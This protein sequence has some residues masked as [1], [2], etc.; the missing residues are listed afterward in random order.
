MSIDTIPNQT[1]F[2]GLIYNP[3]FFSTGNSITLT[4]AT[5][6]FLK[7]TGTN[8]TSDAVLTSFTGNV[9]LN[10]LSTLSDASV[11]GNITV[12]GNTSIIGISNFSNITN[13]SSPTI[14]SNTAS[15]IYSGGIIINKDTYAS[16]I[17]GNNIVTTNV[18][19]ANLNSSNNITTINFNS[20]KITCNQLQANSVFYKGQIGANINIGIPPYLNIPIFTSL[21]DITTGITNFNLQTYLIDSN[22]NTVFVQPY[23]S[24]VFYSNGVIIQIIENSTSSNMLYQTI[25]FS[26][27]LV[28]TS[29]KLLYKT[30]ET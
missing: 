7:R 9:S 23:Y 28:C 27:N 16:D 24:L 25:S 6:N 1:Y 3:N 19:C 14:G 29:I 30:K 18:G 5:Q 8:P 17:M 26:T 4:Y 11:G 15:C 20:N 12:T 21:N 2:N 13:A 22:N 10:K